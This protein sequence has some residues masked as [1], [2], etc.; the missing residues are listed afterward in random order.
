[1]GLE[2]PPGTRSQ[3]LNQEPAVAFGNATEG[4]KPV[5]EGF[6]FLSVCLGFGRS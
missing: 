5:V 3:D 6:R 4:S 1:M 2:L